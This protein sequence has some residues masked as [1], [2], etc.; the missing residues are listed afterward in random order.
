MILSFRKYSGPTEAFRKMKKKKKFL[1]K[2][3]RS[4]FN[5]KKK[6]IPEL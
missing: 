2:T 4:F 6:V 5:K 3:N 1:T